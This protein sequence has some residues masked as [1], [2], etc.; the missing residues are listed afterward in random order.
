MEKV[1]KRKL[2]IEE[3]ILA[4]NRKAEKLEI[5]KRKLTVMKLADGMADGM[6]HMYACMYVCF[7]SIHVFSS[8]IYYVCVCVCAYSFVVVIIVLY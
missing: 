1:V 3:Q 6:Y 7:T 2:S 5:K 8:C 4:A